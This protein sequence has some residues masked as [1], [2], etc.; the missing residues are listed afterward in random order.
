MNVATNE[1]VG[2]GWSKHS[3]GNVNGRNKNW[4][5]AVFAMIARCPIRKDRQVQH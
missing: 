4:A 1:Q 3:E 5:H 2:G